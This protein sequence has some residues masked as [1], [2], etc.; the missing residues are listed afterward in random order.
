[1]SAR[2]MILSAVKDNPDLTTMELVSLCPRP[3][4]HD[5]LNAEYLRHN[6]R[7]LMQM[8]LVTRSSIRPSRWRV[9]E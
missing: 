8:G 1:M 4:Q 6:L 5:N 3:F 2:S 7:V 9:K